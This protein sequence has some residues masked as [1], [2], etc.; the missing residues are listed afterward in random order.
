MNFQEYWPE[1]EGKTEKNKQQFPLME[2][3]NFIKF[4]E[5]SKFAFSI[6]SCHEFNVD[7]AKEGNVLSI[8]A[9]SPI[10]LTAISSSISIILE[11]DGDDPSL[12]LKLRFKL[13]P[14]LCKKKY[15]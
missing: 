4:M 2:G 12:Q 14:N 13:H 3:K 9:P 5:T 1:S 7:G 11:M 8:P 15:N 10:T 6:N